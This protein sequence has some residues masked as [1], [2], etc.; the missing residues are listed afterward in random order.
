MEKFYEGFEKR[1][2]FFKSMAGKVKGFFGRSAKPKPVVAPKAT[3]APKPAAVVKAAP[4]PVRKPSTAKP[5]TLNYAAMAR[6]P[7]LADVVKK[8]KMD[9]LKS[10]KRSRHVQQSMKGT[11]SDPQFRRA[12]V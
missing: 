7:S 9:A 4:K 10:G 3:P 5:Q 6:G 8:K 12:N 11:H 1:A 2:N